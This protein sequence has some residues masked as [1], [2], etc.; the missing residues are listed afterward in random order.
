[1]YQPFVKI[2][3]DCRPPDAPITASDETLPLGFHQPNQTAEALTVFR[4]EIPER[5]E[6]HA[7]FDD[8]ALAFNQE[9]PDARGQLLE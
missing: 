4:G 8:P 2:R 7:M 3:L 1:M 5:E 9:S 6:T